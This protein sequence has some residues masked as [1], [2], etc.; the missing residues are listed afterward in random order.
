MKQKPIVK[1]VSLILILFFSVFAFSQEMF[2]P[3]SNP[4]LS[5]SGRIDTTKVE[6]AL[7]YWSGTSVK[8][9]FKGESVFVLIED[10]NGD[11]YYNVIIDNDSIII[12][13]PDTVKRYYQLVGGLSAK[14]HTLEIFKRTEWNRGNSVF[15]GFKLIGKPKLLPKPKIK[16]R[17]IEFYGNS[18]TAGYAVEDTLGND[19]PD[20]TFT[21]NY[22]S[23]AA[24]TARY[25]DAQYQCICRSGIGVMVSWFPLI[26]P[27]MYYRLDPRDSVSRWDFSLYNP[28]VVVINLFQNDSWLVNMPDNEQF[29]ARF[30]TTPPDDSFIINSCAHFVLSLRKEYPDAKI[31]CILGNMDATKSGSKWP[32]YIKKAVKELNDPEIYTHFIPYKDTPGHPSVKEQEALANSLIN[33]IE[34]N[35]SW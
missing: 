12:F 27:E 8:L 25:F 2:V 16:K 4:N 5:Y 7:F 24:V 23:Y 20:S 33:F 17:K 15:Y 32:G 6:G 3:Y 22:L 10:E 1:T 11:N 28:D 13:K 31:I 18:I 35:I 34:E 30:G 9:N 29:K 19:N 26:M 14:K 21:N